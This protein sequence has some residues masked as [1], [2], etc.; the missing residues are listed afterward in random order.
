MFSIVS[1]DT[2]NRAGLSPHES[3]KRSRLEIAT[4]RALAR[5]AVDIKYS[6]DDNGNWCVAI[7]Q[8]R[9]HYHLFCSEKGNHSGYSR[10]DDSR[11]N[12]YLGDLPKTLL[13]VMSAAERGLRG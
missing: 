2:G 1:S 6:P 10:S 8:P 3:V 4:P 9:S 11:M 5:A 12:F 7:G 13:S